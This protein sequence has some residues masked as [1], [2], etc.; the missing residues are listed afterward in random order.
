MLSLK[1]MLFRR[2]KEVGSRRDGTHVFKREIEISDIN[3]Y[4]AARLKILFLFLL[5]AQRVGGHAL[6][7]AT[8]VLINTSYLLPSTLCLLPFLV[9]VFR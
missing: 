9:I 6:N 2:Q 3:I 4:R 7:S 8:F 1:E 5:L